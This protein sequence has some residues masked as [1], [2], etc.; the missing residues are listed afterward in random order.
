[1]IQLSY[2]STATRSMNTDDLMDI[3]RTARAHNADR[4]ITGMLLYSNGTF[5]QVLEGEEAVLDD[6]LARI[7]RD[8]RHTALRVLERKKIEQ[9]EYADWSMGFKRVSREKLRNTPGLSDFFEQDF[10][11]DNLG[12]RLSLIHK[13][14]GHFRR[15]EQRRIGHDE[16]SL[17]DEDRFIVVLHWLIRVAV[18]ALA[19]L[20][21]FTILW[22]VVDVSVVIYQKTIE[23]PITVL[24]QEDILKVFGSFMIVLIAIEIFI[25]ITLYIRSHVIPV[26]LV[27]AT[28]LMAVAR[29]II[30]FDYHE[31]SALHV[32]GTAL[33]VLALGSTY[34]LLEREFN[35]HSADSR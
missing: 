13:L 18:K 19:I 5:V 32:I 20:M 33:L 9:R 35:P 29:K 6:L 11:A 7:K 1:M 14:L 8:T 23:Q 17:E 4:G 34:W 21:V 12:D 31:V 24:A 3:L 10:D 22:S 16:L 25:N 30:V 27:V 26:K 28:A 15:E 2:I